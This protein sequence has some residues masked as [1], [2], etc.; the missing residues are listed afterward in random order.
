MLFEAVEPAL[1]RRQFPPDKD[2][3]DPLDLA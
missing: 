1:D 2:L 3:A